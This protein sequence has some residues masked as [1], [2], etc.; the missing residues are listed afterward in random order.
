MERARGLERL[1]EVFWACALPM[2]LRSGGVVDHGHHLLPVAL[3]VLGPPIIA[4]LGQGGVV[5]AIASTEVTD[6]LGFAA[7]VGLDCLLIG[8][9]LGG[10]VQEL[11]HHVCGLMAKRV[12]ERLT[13][14]ATNEGVDDVGVGDVGELVALIGETLDVLPKGLIGPL[15]TVVEVP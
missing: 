2:G 12:D 1:L 8:G 9:I 11:P 14:R 4:S 10:N 5:T 3:L 6:G 15:P 7:E 13:G